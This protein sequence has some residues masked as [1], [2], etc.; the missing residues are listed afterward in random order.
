MKSEGVIVA[1][2][3]DRLLHL[4]SVSYGTDPEISIVFEQVQ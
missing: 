4:A 3:F 1:M 2:Y